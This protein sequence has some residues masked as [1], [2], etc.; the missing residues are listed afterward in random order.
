MLDA[1]VGAAPGMHLVA[2]GATEGPRL[3]DARQLEIL[4]AVSGRRQW[5]GN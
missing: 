3:D 5:S 4:G 1:G 2:H